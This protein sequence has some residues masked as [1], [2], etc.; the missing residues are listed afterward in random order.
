MVAVLIDTFDTSI[1]PRVPPVGVDRLERSRAAAPEAPQAMVMPWSILHLAAVV[2]L[3]LVGLIGLRVAQSYAAPAAPA[4]AEATL[5][6]PVIA[7]G[8]Q[9]VLM[10]DGDTLESVAASIAPGDPTW[11]YDL[12]V[13]RNGLSAPSAGEYLVV[14]VEL[15]Q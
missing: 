12:L 14:P 13:R 10:A 5:D 3:L 1:S 4:V 8:E 2:A 9:L 7:P 15:V 6:A 11:A